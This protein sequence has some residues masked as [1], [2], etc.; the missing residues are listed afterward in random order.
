MRGAGG[1]KAGRSVNGSGFLFGRLKNAQGFT[2]ES[3]RSR[4]DLLEPWGGCGACVVICCRRRFFKQKTRRRMMRGI[5]NRH[6]AFSKL[7]RVVPQRF[8]LGES[9]S[10]DPPSPRFNLELICALAK[11]T[12]FDA[13]GFIIHA[14]RTVSTFL[15]QIISVRQIGAGEQQIRHREENLFD[16]HP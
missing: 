14:R 6:G 7:G 3:S 10:T 11:E 4:M 5:Q 16:S 12:V 1:R 13:F 9:V 15:N 2:I 8:L